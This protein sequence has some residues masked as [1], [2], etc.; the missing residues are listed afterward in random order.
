MY[1]K[2]YKLVTV[3]EHRCVLKDSLLWGRWNLISKRV[4]VLCYKDTYRRDDFSVNL[5]SLGYM[6]S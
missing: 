6:K 4:A 1:T 5:S 2:L 3:N